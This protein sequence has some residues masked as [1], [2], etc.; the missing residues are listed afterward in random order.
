MMTE[1]SFLGELSLYMLL[2]GTAPCN[3][4]IPHRPTKHGDTSLLNASTFRTEKDHVAH[5]E[6]TLAPS[7]P[8]AMPGV[9][10]ASSGGLLCFYFES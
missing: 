5:P 9:S 3:T 4:N 6:L 10:S 1:F 2:C 7:L 8:H